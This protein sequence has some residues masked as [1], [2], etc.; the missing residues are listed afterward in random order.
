ML[1]YGSSTQRRQQNKG[2]KKEVRGMLTIS[3]VCLMSGDIDPALIRFFIVTALFVTAVA[4][5]GYVVFR[6]LRKQTDAGVGDQLK[7]EFER[8]KAVLLAAAQARK[9]ASQQQEAQARVAEKEQKE[10]D[11]LKENVD[12]QRIFGQSCPLCGLEMTDDQELVID[13]YTGQGY[14]LSSFLNDWPRDAER[15]VYVYR[16]P[17]GEVVRS[18]KL[19]LR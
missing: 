1:R 15:P 8:S 4:V 9:A 6:I 10:R 16:Y 7:S 14:H 18:D 13:P 17:D 5:G 3:F 2:S 19:I 11:L 12:P